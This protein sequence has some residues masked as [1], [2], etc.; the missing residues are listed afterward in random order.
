MKFRIHWARALVLGLALLAAGCMEEDPYEKFT[1]TWVFNLQNQELRHVGDTQPLLALSVD[2]ARKL[3][4]VTVL[5][6]A[7]SADE[8][9]LV[10]QPILNMETRDGSL[11][12]NLEKVAHPAW[13][14]MAPVMFGSLILEPLD[15]DALLAKIYPNAVPLKDLLGND[16]PKP[17]NIEEVKRPDDEQ[18]KLLAEAR[19]SSSIALNGDWYLE[20]SWEK[21]AM[22]LDTATGKLKLRDTQLIKLRGDSTLTRSGYLETRDDKTHGAVMVFANTRTSGGDAMFARDLG[23]QPPEAEFTLRGKEFV[24]LPD[25]SEAERKQRAEARAEAR[26]QAAREELD[27][28]RQAEGEA[29]EAKRHAEAEARMASEKARAAVTARQKEL[30]EKRAK[31]PEF[32]FNDIRLSDTPQQMVQKGLERYKLSTSF[33]VQQKGG[34]VGGITD[35]VIGYLPFLLEDAG[36]ADALGGQEAQRLKVA[37][38]YPRVGMEVTTGYILGPDDLALRAGVRP[39]IL[40]FTDKTRK[41]PTS[42]LMNIGFITLPGKAPRPLY[43][44][45]DGDIVVDALSVFRERYGEPESVIHGEGNATQHIWRSDN[46]VAILRVDPK[47]GKGRQHHELYIISL[48]AYAELQQFTQNVRQAEEAKRKAAEEAERAR[49]KAEED[50]RKAGI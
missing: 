44:N 12:M 22:A 18:R 26:R 46:E 32:S 27:A 23:K 13:E 2:A 43:L 14:G 8:W 50:A 24:L 25:M 35:P 29:L 28:K 17:G 36:V 3:L 40:M 19:S 20:D 38:R 10:E 48:P 45:V 33:P 39:D 49:Q 4:T 16:P 41:D 11:A 34:S 5:K 21:P 15:K 47:D 42:T 31:M 6:S 7:T 37:S 1:G 9:T 30:A